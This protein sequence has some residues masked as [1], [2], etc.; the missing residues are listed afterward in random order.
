MSSY[1]SL[2]I[3]I[4]AAINPQ[5]SN[6]AAC[7]LI[8]SW[9]WAAGNSADLEAKPLCRD[10]IPWW[11]WVWHRIKLITVHFSAV[12]G[13]H[14]VGQWRTWE[15]TPYNKSPSR[16]RGQERTLVFQTSFLAVSTPIWANDRLSG[17]MDRQTLSHVTQTLLGMCLLSRSFSYLSAGKRPGEC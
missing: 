12:W 5:F 4:L 13:P 17:V 7:P 8:L 10:S 14:A 15:H 2:F 11:S 6:I 16:A 3:Y 1:L 9:K